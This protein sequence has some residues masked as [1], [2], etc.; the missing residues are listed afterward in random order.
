MASWSV[1]PVLENAINTPQYFNDQKFPHQKLSKIWQMG[2]RYHHPA[3]RVF[4][5]PALP[6][7]HNVR[8]ARVG[9]WHRD[10]PEQNSPEREVLVR[11]SCVRHGRIMDPWQP[12]NEEQLCG[13]I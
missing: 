3:R 2:L 12:R 1:E 8:M 13:F 11:G 4:S 9:G 5:V 6:W 7:T 10:H